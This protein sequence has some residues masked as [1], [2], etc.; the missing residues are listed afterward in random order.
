LRFLSECDRGELPDPSPEPTGSHEVPCPSSARGDG[1]PPS[2]VYLARFVPPSG[3]R[4][5][6]AVYSSRNRPGLFHP[7]G[8]RRVSRPSKHSPARGRSHLLGD[9]PT[10]VPLAEAQLPGLDPSGSPLPVLA[11][12]NPRDGSLLP[13]VSSPPGVA[14]PRNRPLG[15]SSPVL[16]VGSPERPHRGTSES[17]LRGGWSP[18]ARPPPLLGFSRPLPW[19]G[20]RSSV[21]LL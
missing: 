5:L 15:S 7:G 9:R 10:R 14:T 21:G 6:L 17:C 19:E 12:V 18:L 20:R 1:S 11:G 4:T 13:W 8:T 2:R 3:F 16:S